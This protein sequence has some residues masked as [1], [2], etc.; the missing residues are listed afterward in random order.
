MLLKK[1]EDTFIVHLFWGCTQSN[2]GDVFFANKY[3]VC[4]RQVDY[5]YKDNIVPIVK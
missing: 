5:K 3:H 2:N 1:N 4:C